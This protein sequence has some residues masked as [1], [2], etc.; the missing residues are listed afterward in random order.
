MKT[1]EDIEILRADALAGDAGAQNDLGCAYSSGDGVV[2]NLKEAFAWFERSAKQGNKYGQY[3]TGRYYQYGFGVG[4]NISLAIEWYKKSAN[5]GFGKAA[6]MLGEIYEKGYNPIIS[7]QSFNI[8]DITSIE[9]NPEEAFYW[10]KKGQNNDDI[11]KFNLARCYELGIGTPKSLFMA[12][13]LY[14][15]CKNEKAKQKLETIKETYNPI[16]DTSLQSIEI[17]GNNPYRILGIWGNSS[18]REIRA[19][20]S[21]IEA[22]SKVG[23]TTSFES[24]HLI[25]CDVADF[26]IEYENRIN[27]LEDRIKSVFTQREFVEENIKRC[28][29]TLKDWRSVEQNIPSWNIYPNRDEENVIN[30]KTKLASE[31]ER[32][33]YALFWFCNYT[34][35][36]EKALKL[37]S[38][39][40]WYEAK[41][42]WFNK[43]NFSACINDAVMQLAERNYFSAIISILNLIH[44]EAFRKEFVSVISN[45]AVELS[46]EELSQMFWDTLYEFPETE[47][48]TQDVLKYG[49]GQASLNERIL[50]E[51]D[52]EY[53]RKKGFDIYEAPIK[54][55][56]RYATNQD[57]NDFEESRKVYDKIVKEA[58]IVLTRI[59]RLVGDDNYRYKLLCNEVAE[60][61]LNYA[62][63]F[64]NDKKEDYS[65]PATALKYA[66]Y[67]LTVVTDENLRERCEENVGIFKRNDQA[68]RIEKLCNDIESKFSNFKNT[69][70]NFSEV[71]KL[72]TDVS[73][74]VVG[75]NIMTGKDSEL[76]KNI[77]DRVVNELLNIIISICNKENDAASAY[78]ASELM[79]KVKRMYMH[80]NTQKRLEKNLEIIT[81]NIGAAISMGNYGYSQDT[82]KSYKYYQRTKEE[83]SSRQFVKGFCTFG[84]LVF[85]FVMWMYLRYKNNWGY[86]MDTMPWLGYICIIFMVLVALFIIIMWGLEFQEDPYDTEFVWIEKAYDG[87]MK[88]ANEITMAGA[89]DGKTYSWPFA[90]PFQ[91]LALTIG[92]IGFPVRWLAKLAALIK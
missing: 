52:K 19:N 69:S 36:D 4:K 77:S 67:A 70:I 28:K 24:D 41:N 75:I 40:K 33:K 47:L 17:L 48:S 87:L 5:Q 91:I 13:K 54:D 64:N 25:S 59:K 35:N 92:F 83:D 55:M 31:K 53:N 38:E 26:I 32:I 9:A 14:S 42:I 56:L 61:L 88:I 79:Q 20:L 12:C 66:T 51:K 82:K 49:S 10:Y 78:R 2:K 84:A 21:K 44:K 34:P 80:P 23:K 27:Y 22:M 65:A 6:N 8:D 7:V 18:E 43:I 90:I 74:H 11:A 71:E 46:E 68:A 15:S 73:S 81:H 1:K 16:L 3:N 50:P 39:H 72:Y 37:L 30:S 45:G 62:I 85:L 63:H 76:Y 57:E 29:E 86:F 58:P 89:R 60:K